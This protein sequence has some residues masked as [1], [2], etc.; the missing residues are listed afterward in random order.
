MNRFLI[1]FKAAQSEQTRIKDQEPEINR[2]PWLL[3]Q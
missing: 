3:N 2:Q 1:L